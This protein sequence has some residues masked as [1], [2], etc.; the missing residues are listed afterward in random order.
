VQA[1][2]FVQYKYGLNISTIN[3]VN[4][5]ENKLEVYNK[6]EIMKYLARE[7]KRIKGEPIPEALAEKFEEEA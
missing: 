1:T 5:K 7:Y 2:L 3:N 6:L 4:D